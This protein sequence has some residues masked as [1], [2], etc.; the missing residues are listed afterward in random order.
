M[1]RYQNIILLITDALSGTLALYL[2]YVLR[3]ESALF[4]AD[5]TTQVVQAS[6]AIAV[7]WWA[8]TPMVLFWWVVFAANGLYNRN[9]VIS[10]FDELAKVFKSV[11]IGVVIIY[12]ATFDRTQPVALTQ[13][14]L[15]LYAAEMFILVGTTRFLFRNVQR[16]F[17]WRGIGLEDAIIIGC[18]EVGRQLFEQLDRYPVWGF[19]IVGFV[20]D[21]FAP[22]NASE[23]MRPIGRTADLPQIIKDAKVR[24]ILIAPAEADNRK[25]MELL[26]LSISLPV[27]VMLVADYYQM[28]VGLVGTVQIHGLPF[29]EV[30]RRLISPLVIILKRAMDIV[31]SAVMCAMVLI[32]TPL[33]AALIKL[34]SRGPVFYLQRRVGKQSREFTM[35][36]YRSMVHDA[37]R[38]TGVV[39]AQKNDPR[40]TRVGRFLRRAHLDELPQFFNVLLG[41]M[42]LVGPRPERREFVSEFRHKVPLYGATPD[43]PARHHRLG[44]NPPQ[45][46][47]IVA[48][49]H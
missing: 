7:F 30:S 32:I 47:R 36:K 38:R 41:Q 13:I 5:P 1:K 31:V 33:L 27:R 14:G 18:N 28:V 8:L 25:M 4:T 44:A 16:Y 11:V 40:I 45:I 35:Y 29:I 17:R 24:W 49:C 19:R 3:F 42:S 34:D 48:R 23:N 10:R 26:D 43:S 22:A 2:T 37:E 39:W 15:L 12:I 6:G 46:R 21:V 9:V 20:D